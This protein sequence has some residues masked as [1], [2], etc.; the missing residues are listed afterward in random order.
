MSATNASLGFGTVIQRGDIATP[1]NFAALAEMKDI[2][3]PNIE[4]DSQEATH[5][6]SPDDHKEF[7]PGLVDGG[8][9][10]VECQVVEDGTERGNIIADLQAR[11]TR[12][13]RI[14]FPS[15]GYW[16]FKAFLTG[17]Q[18]ANPVQDIMTDSLS[19]KITGKPTWTNP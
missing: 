6:Q 16:T 8:E 7:I 9:V 19:W 4:V 17:F 3:G 5:Q 2:S 12:Y 11:L 10:S 1:T 15:G 13:W 18:A 14:V